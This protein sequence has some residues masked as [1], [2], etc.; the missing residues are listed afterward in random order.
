MIK[1][2]LQQIIC[3]GTLM[4]TAVNLTPVFA[5]QSEDG[6]Y[7]QKN[8]TNTQVNVQLLSDSV[9]DVDDEE[10]SGKVIVRHIDADTGKELTREVY[11]DMPYGEVKITSVLNL[12]GYTLQDSKEKIVYVTAN[13]P[14]VTVTFKYKSTASSTTKPDSSGSGNNNNSNNNSSTGDNIQ[15]PSNNTTNNNNTTSNNTKPNNTTSNNTKPN[16]TINNN[17]K[18]NTNNTSNSTKPTTNT[19]NVNAIHKPSTSTNNNSNKNDTNNPTTNVIEKDENES[20]VELGSITINCIDINSGE[21]FKTIKKDKLS[22][23][24]VH[25]YSAIDV[26]GYTLHDESIKTVELSEANPHKTI[27]FKYSKN[28]SVSTFGRARL[29]EAYNNKEE[30]TAYFE[31]GNVSINNDLIRT[32]LD[33]NK[34][35][36]ILDLSEEVSKK[37][38]IEELS[39]D[40]DLNLLSMFSLSSNLYGEDIEESVV[41]TT[42]LDEEYNNKTVHVY[43]LASDGSADY[44]AEETVK[45]GV[46]SFETTLPVNEGSEELSS[47]DY[48]VSDTKLNEDVETIVENET[49]DVAQD[50]VQDVVQDVANENNSSSALV[51]VVVSTV[52][53]I[54][55]IF[56]GIKLFKAK[57]KNK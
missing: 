11:D 22:L 20:K 2:K 42:N 17:T 36:L 19:N 44:V 56:G 13:N 25:T 27:S 14:V 28:N 52:A 33:S 16:N 6:Q 1:K 15:K 41:I 7:S 26:N 43:K 38:V 24:D 12:S 40:N 4:S 48:F 37:D 49:Q 50:V 34:T 46:I 54:G 21:I 57:K 53:S 23:T 32:I 3:A 10:G 39:N 47:I 45:D 5:H 9:D 55:V 51:Y 8:T 31:V 18:P 29:Q 30:V 35:N